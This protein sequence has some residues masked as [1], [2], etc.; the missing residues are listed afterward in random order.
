MEGLA[1]MP[2]DSGSSWHELTNG[3]TSYKKHQNKPGPLPTQIQSPT[4]L[5]DPAHRFLALLQRGELSSSQLR[6]FEIS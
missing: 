3:T 6:V 1:Q 5:D 4:Q 2:S